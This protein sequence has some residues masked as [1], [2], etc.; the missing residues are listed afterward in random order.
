ML[1]VHMRLLIIKQLIS[2][3][4]YAFYTEI[5]N[6]I[7]GSQKL[8]K[9]DIWKTEGGNQNIYHQLFHAKLKNPKC[10]E[11]M[12]LVVGEMCYCSFISTM[13]LL[14]GTAHP[15]RDGLFL[16]SCR[17]WYVP[18]GDFVRKEK[19]A[20]FKWRHFRRKY[21]YI[22]LILELDTVLTTKFTLACPKVCGFK[23]NRDTIMWSQVKSFKIIL[24]KKEDHHNSTQIM[25]FIEPYIHKRH[26][27]S[28]LLA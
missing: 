10:T 21:P 20:I 18:T 8:T 26:N 23:F 13:L 1:Y 14:S 17:P 19:Y 5:F 3:P 28:N 16:S 24:T 22:L 12:F 9:D 6:W 11:I 15:N 25:P 7:K 4:A 2:I 27:C